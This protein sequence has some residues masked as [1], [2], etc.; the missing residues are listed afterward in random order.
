MAF[1]LDPDRPFDEAVRKVAISQLEDAMRALKKQPD[2]IHEA[3]HDARKKFKRVRG[4][5]RL[6][7]PAAKAFAREE[8]ARIRELARTLSA[9]RDA[10]AMI[11]CL[12]YLR[13]KAADGD[14]D[15]ALARLEAALAARRDRMAS[16]DDALQKKAKDAIT[17]C[18]D[19]IAAVERQDF[20]DVK[21][22]KALAKAW[23]KQLD[24]AH[25]A[26]MAVR[27]E[28]SDEHFHELRK[29]A[30]TY[31]MFCALVSPLWPSALKAKR[32]DAKALADLV[33]HEHDL[34][35]LIALLESQDA[36][37]MPLD[38]LGLCRKAAL[39]ERALLRRRAVKSAR[40]VFD[41]DADMEAAVI[42]TL[43][44]K[45]QARDEA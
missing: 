33:G 6:I 32:A 44:K 1:T 3:I 7:R 24:A 28:E 29:E 5:Y 42:R 16:G 45:H 26:V 37:D 41:D 12:H 4:L 22:Q 2:G 39:A 20:D 27:A 10:A 21:P 40:K 13:Q 14:T 9:D 15:M 23:E 31:W 36:P 30:Q 8:N 19:A 38:V 43:W 17:V 34:S 25:V 11:E 18:R 35:G